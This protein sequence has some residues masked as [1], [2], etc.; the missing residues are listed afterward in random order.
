MSY[1][2]ETYHCKF[3]CTILFEKDKV[4]DFS[5]NTITVN[6]ESVINTYHNNEGILKCVKC[7]SILGDDL[8]IFGNDYYNFY[9]LKGMEMLF[10]SV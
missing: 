10:S 7:S 8:N 4:I 2:C 5:E 3:C 9:R 6:D 1:S